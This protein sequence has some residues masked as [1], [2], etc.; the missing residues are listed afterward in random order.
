MNWLEVIVLSILQ[1]VAE[2]LP[3]S[4]SGHLFLLQRLM[5]LSEGMLFF[6][7]M[8][9]FASGLAILII[10]RKEVIE[11]FQNK[12][13]FLNILLATIPV[14][15]V[16][17]LIKDFVDSMDKYLIIV[18]FGLILT[19][20]Y[21]F[22]MDRLKGKLNYQE[23]PYISALK[24]GLL[25]IVAILPGVSR[26]GST[27]VGGSLVGLDRESALK[28]SFLMALP[29]IFGASGL[30]LFGAIKDNDLGNVGLWQTIFGVLIC[31]I[32]SWLTISWLL[33]KIKKISF[34]YFAYYT[35]VLGLIV[36]YLNL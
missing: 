34:K 14:V 9:H 3:I 4:S 36:I 32:V 25:Q 35:F 11:I 16:G 10:L 30:E 8:L 20:G 33:T 5:G 17:L 19:A 24:V 12:K 26:S 31:F 18:G 1:G 6:D 28:F 2:F 7:V 27:I 29:A 22:F 21:N 13:L 23:I 15:I